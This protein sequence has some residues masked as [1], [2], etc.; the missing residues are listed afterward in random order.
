M[1]KIYIFLIV[2]LSIFASCGEDFESLTPNVVSWFSSEDRHVIVVAFVFPGE[3]DDQRLRASVHSKSNVLD[4][5]D[6]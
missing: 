4:K 6:V 5:W 1:Q 3:L 2:L